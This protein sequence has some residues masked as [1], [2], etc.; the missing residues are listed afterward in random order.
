[1]TPLLYDR[2]RA[3]ALLPLLRSI[4]REIQDRTTGL[5][6]IEAQLARAEAG[7]PIRADV[8][9]LVATAARHR[10]EIRMARE[11]LERLGCSIVGTAPLTIRIPGRRGKKRH[12]FVYQGGDAILR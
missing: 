9:D 2:T 6:R 3:T 5:E 7:K 11:E 8:H 1:M 4:S 12:S 10:R